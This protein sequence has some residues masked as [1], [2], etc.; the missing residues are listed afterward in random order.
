MPVEPDPEPLEN[1]PRLRSV[2][3]RARSRLPAT[4]IRRVVTFTSPPLQPLLYRY[5]RHVAGRW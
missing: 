3:I 4:I 5:L 1:V 2:R